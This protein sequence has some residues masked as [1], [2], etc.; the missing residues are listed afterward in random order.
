MDGVMQ[1]AALLVSMGTAAAPDAAQA[2]GLPV[3]GAVAPAVLHV[4]VPAP[5]FDSAAAIIPASPVRTGVPV[6]LDN[7]RAMRHAPILQVPADSWTSEDKFRH[8][9]ASWAAMVFTYA[10]VRSINDDPD[11]AIAVALPVTAALGVAKEIVDRRRGGPFSFRDLTADAL[12]AAV[13]W[14]FLREMR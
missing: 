8:A 4:H 7:G 2:I 14:L 3:N 9:A 11:A 1:V 5:L 10:G 13:A 6:T 12:G